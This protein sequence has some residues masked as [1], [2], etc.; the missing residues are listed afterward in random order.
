M[1]TSFPP[2]TIIIFVKTISLLSLLDQ[3]ESGE[4]VFER[5]EWGGTGY[6]SRLQGGPQRWFPNQNASWVTTVLVDIVRTYV[7]SWRHSTTSHRQIDR[8]TDR[9]SWLMR[10]L[11]RP[12]RR[13]VSGQLSSNPR[14]GPL[15]NRCA[16]LARSRVFIQATPRQMPHLRTVL[17]TYDWSVNAFTHRA[18]KEQNK[19]LNVWQAAPL[20]TWIYSTGFP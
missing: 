4:F 16:R 6:K 18:H 19:L 20:A 10:D 14:S 1:I 11:W 5:C 15:R 2:I 9:W 13:A 3:F 8:Q 12:T 17:H 7:T